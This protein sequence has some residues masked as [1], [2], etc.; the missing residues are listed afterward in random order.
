VAIHRLH[1]G[2]ELVKTARSWPWKSEPNNE[3]VT[4]HE[5][6]QFAPKMEK[7]R[8]V[9][10]E[11]QLCALYIYCCYVHTCRNTWR[12]GWRGQFV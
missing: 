7:A 2:G 10:S 11:I 8:I 9:R 5:P 6:N 1:K 12:R 3:C 4:T